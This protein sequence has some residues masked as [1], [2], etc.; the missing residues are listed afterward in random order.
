MTTPWPSSGSRRTS[1]QDPC[2]R[3]L[4]GPS[5]GVAVIPGVDA[6]M[7]MVRTA[8]NVVGNCLASVVI[9]RWEGVF[10]QPAAEGPSSA[11]TSS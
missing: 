4:L 3:T 1:P 8:T 5:S 10:A 11:A 9:A 7:D 2:P 6:L